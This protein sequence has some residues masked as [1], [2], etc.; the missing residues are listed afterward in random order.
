MC[1]V[2]CCIIMHYHEAP[3][4]LS[5]RFPVISSCL[6]ITPN[7]SRSHCSGEP[8]SDVWFHIRIQV[9]VLLIVLL[10]IFLPSTQMREIPRNDA[11]G[12]PE[13]SPQFLPRSQWTSGLLK[14]FWIRVISKENQKK[15]MVLTIKNLGKGLKISGC[16]WNYHMK[17]AASAKLLK[18]QW[19]SLM[20]EPSSHIGIPYTQA[21]HIYYI[22]I[23]KYYK[24]IYI[25][26][27]VYYT[28]I[29]TYIH[30][31]IYMYIIL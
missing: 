10:N 2:K 20:C 16:A 19:D 26:T 15:T 27:H 18:S 30:I 8:T 28:Y 13:F 12:I 23:I 11:K 1:H 4:R 9:A 24:Y 5:E 3:L 31:Y 7:F 17:S 29:H 14:I 25:Y 6:K 22:Y 21:Q